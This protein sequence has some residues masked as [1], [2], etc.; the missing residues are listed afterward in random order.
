MPHAKGRAGRM[1]HPFHHLSVF[2]KPTKKAL[3]EA[4]AASQAAPE[5]TT[6]PIADVTPTTP[7]TP[8]A[9]EPAAPKKSGWWPFGSKKSEATL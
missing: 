8:Q 7:I 3:R 2:V 5:A 4:A 6:A 1:H 9:Q